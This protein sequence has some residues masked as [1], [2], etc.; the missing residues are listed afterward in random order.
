MELADDSTQWRYLVGVLT[1]VNIGI[2]YEKEE[3][4]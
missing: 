3:A 4:S 2:S 1:V